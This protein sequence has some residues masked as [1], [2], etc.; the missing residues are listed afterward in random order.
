MEKSR[1]LKVVQGEPVLAQSAVAAVK[2]W[3]YQPFL[4]DGKPVKTETS[5]TIDFKFPSPS[6]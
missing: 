3:R 6:H 1:D 4:L 2:Q 5:I